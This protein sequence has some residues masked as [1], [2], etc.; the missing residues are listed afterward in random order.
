MSNDAQVQVVHATLGRNDHG[1]NES[2]KHYGDIHDTYLYISINHDKSVN[3]FPLAG[4]LIHSGD[5]Q[6]VKW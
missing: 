6:R 5:L 2:A 4:K 3:M 1:T